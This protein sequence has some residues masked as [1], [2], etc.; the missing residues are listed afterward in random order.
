MTAEAKVGA[1]FAEPETAWP[2][3]APRRPGSTALGDAI[4]T[5]GNAET[6]TIALLRYTKSGNEWAIYWRD[7]ILRFNRHDRV[8]PSENVEDL[9]GIDRDPTCISWG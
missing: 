1:S 7:R 6:A 3:T 9:D 5:R 8:A 4:Q 2:T